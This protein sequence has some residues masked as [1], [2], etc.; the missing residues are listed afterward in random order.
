M[1]NCIRCG[2]QLPGFSFGKKIC[3]WCVQHEAAQRGE[4]ADDAPQPIMRTPWVRR[5]ESAIGLTQIIFGINAAVFLG[6]ALSASTVMDF[7][8]QES[9]R[10]GANYGPL[11]LSGEWWRLLTNIFIHGGIIH[12][13]FNM[14]CLWNLGALCEAL[15]GGWTYGAIYL[16]CG[17]GASLAS[18]AWHPN[19]PSVG[20]SGAIF[21]LAGALI[22]AFKL[23]E[24][25]VPRSALS[26]TLRSL[27]AFVVY[28]LIFGQLMPGIDNTAHIGGL[29]TGLIVGALIALLA[30]HQEHAPR[31]V[32]ILLLS[33]LALAGVAAGTAYHYGFSLRLGRASF[34]NENPSGHSVANLEKIVKQRPDF[35]PARFD[36]AQAYFSQAQYAK[37]ESQLKRVLEL[38]PQN[39][40]ARTLMGMVY[41][42]ENRPQDAKDIFSQAIS[43]DANNAEAHFGLGLALAAQGNHQAA[44]E[45]YKTAAR[46]E[47]QADGVNYNMGL[48]YAKLNQY[49]DAIAAF[50]REQKQSGDGP[51]IET[52]LANAYQAKGL[53]PQADE[54]RGK[55]A[56]FKKNA[57]D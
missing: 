2:R 36:L 43:Q 9:I 42:N 44:I 7:P 15:Y 46:L 19:G 30:P 28:N 5:G 20:A 52:A 23:G 40:D 33:L 16:I 24:F 51:E 49:D 37:A 11:T 54:A 8:I 35:V 34:S 27:G 10:W 48:S 50:L 45:E 41:L 56:Q 18:V 55:A 12:I 38:Q 39:A 3:Q 6:M 22:A 31:R 21:G 57:S 13:A 14:W 53:T 47:P 32:A 29:V 26:G 25:S 1:A 17:I 4:L